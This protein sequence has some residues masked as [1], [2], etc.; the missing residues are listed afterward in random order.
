MI[1]RLHLSAL[2]LTAALIWGLLLVLDGVVVHASWLRPFSLVT[3]ILLIL[4]AGFDLFLWRVP[5][6]HPWFVGRPNLRG[7]WRAVLRSNWSKPSTQETVAPIQ[8][9]VVI[10]QTFSR[11]SLRLMTEESRSELLGAEVLRSADGTYRLVGVYRNEPKLGVRNRSPIHNGALVL[12]FAGSPPTSLEGHYWTDRDTA[13]ELVLTDRQSKI[14]D[15]VAAARA[16]YGDPQQQ[17]S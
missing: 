15:D 1:E 4:L 8:G 11:L 7:T 2:V 9:Y 14:V 16:L 17:P 5:F 6:L 10:S 3:G 12:Q 13:G